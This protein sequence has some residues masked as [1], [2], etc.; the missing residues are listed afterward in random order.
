MRFFYKGKDRV[1]EVIK[2]RKTVRDLFY[3]RFNASNHSSYIEH[4]NYSIDVKY[5]SGH[6]IHTLFCNEDIYNNLNIGDKYFVHIHI[7]EV[8]K[9]YNSQKK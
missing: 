8:T 5:N 6:R 9:I 1:I 4:V 3:P 7:H 2:R